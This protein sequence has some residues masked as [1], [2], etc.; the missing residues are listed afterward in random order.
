MGLVGCINLAWALALAG[1][2]SAAALPLCW[3]RLWFLAAPAYGWLTGLAWYWAL[4]WFCCY[5][6]ILPAC[7]CRNHNILNPDHENMGLP[8]PLPC[9]MGSAVVGP[10]RA[11]PGLAW[12]Q[13]L[14]LGWPWLGWVIGGA[15]A[16]VLAG[17]GL[18]VLHCRACYHTN[19]QPTWPWT[20]TI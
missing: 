3:P 10:V 7:T 6:N 16:C 9:C 2:A 4:A 19:I 5:T 12:V 20:T 11:L 13:G 17:T 15:L 14:G 18:L 8:D 1:S